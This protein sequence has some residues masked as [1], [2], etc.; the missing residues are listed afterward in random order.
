LK[1]ISNILVEVGGCMAN[2]AYDKV[3]CEGARPLCFKVTFRDLERL[4]I[5]GRFGHVLMSM[6][7][8]LA[9]MLRSRVRHIY[10]VV[11]RIFGKHE[12]GRSRRFLLSTQPLDEAC[13]LRLESQRYL[14][15]MS[16]LSFSVLSPHLCVY[17][18][19]LNRVPPHAPYHRFPALQHSTLPF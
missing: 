7:F 10:D 3:F 13:I 18:W 6:N 1:N 4:L 14:T 16:A 8:R 19:T 11:G 15:T 12:D 9:Q 17:H 5:G 2:E